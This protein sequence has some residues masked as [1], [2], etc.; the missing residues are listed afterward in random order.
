MIQNFNYNQAIKQASQ[1]EEIA[2]E[3]R[4]VANSKLSNAIATIDASW[5]GD[6]SNLFLRHCN[7]T[8]QQIAAR[9]SELDNLAHRIREVARIRREA[10][11]ANLHRKG[12]P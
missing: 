6:T 5:D 10:E 3:M 2:R 8:K 11:L 4:S 9:A 1:V 12:S 7:D